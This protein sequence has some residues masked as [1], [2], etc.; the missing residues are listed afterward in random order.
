MSTP[1]EIAGLLRRDMLIGQIEPG[2]ELHQEALA[3]RFGVSRMPVRDALNLLARD[4][5][6]SL[7]PNRASHVTALSRDELSEIYD[8]RLMLE[9]DLLKL[10]MRNIGADELA[11]IRREMLRC[12]IEAGTQ[13]FPEADWKFHLALY[14]PAKRPRQI[15]MIKELRELCQ[16]HRAAYLRLQEDSD[17]WSDDHRKIFEAISNRQTRNAVTCLK[18]HISDARNKLLSGMATYHCI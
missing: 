5:L 11:Q 12:E 7:R 3:S 17:K 18:Q 15:A 2:D 16:I 14:T 6:V 4:G 9:A 8:L 13:D 10:S 1:H